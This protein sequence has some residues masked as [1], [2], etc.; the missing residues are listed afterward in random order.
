MKTNF[1][2]QLPKTIFL[3]LALRWS[4]VFS[5]NSWVCRWII[6]ILKLFRVVSRYIPFWV[7]KTIN[8]VSSI[9]TTPI[10]TNRYR[11]SKIKDF[12]WVK[13]LFENL[14]HLRGLNIPACSS[15]LPKFQFNHPTYKNPS[16]FWLFYFLTYSNT[17]L[18]GV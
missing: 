16:D 2:S 9:L 17:K 13:L 3:L 1:V 6:W 14:I 12:Q 15:L 18:Y 10:I 7:P 8:Q 11:L 5:S 4:S